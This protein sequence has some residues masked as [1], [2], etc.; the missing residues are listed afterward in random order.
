MKVIDLFSGV[1]GLSLGFENAG[2]ES[3]FAL[4]YNEGV[5]DGYRQNFKKT[6]VVCDDISSINLNETFRDYKNVDT[7]VIGGPPCQGFSQKGKRLGL[8]D[9]RNFLFKKYIEAVKII[10]PVGF[11]IENVPG[12]LSAEKGFFLDE[13]QNE[14]YKLNY[15]LSYRVLDASD[16]GI[17][18]KRK[19]AFI[20]GL[21]R[22]LEFNWPIKSEIIVTIEDAISDLP[23]LRS[24]EGETIQKYN[25]PPRS[26]YQA[27]LRKGSNKIY[28]HI[29][30]KHSSLVLERLQM[31]P[32]N[33]TRD[34]LPEEHLT[35]S[36][37]SGTWCR[38]IKNEPA[39]TI[40]TRF[41]TP[42]SG[43][44]T[45]PDQDRCLTVRE[46][47]RIQS[48]PDNFIFTGGK[49]NQM[50]Q[51]GNAVPPLLSATIAHR[52]VKSLNLK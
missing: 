48:F 5:I 21:K 4:D 49:S 47:A 8:N 20:I 3:I 38:L 17:P 50:L 19:R 51:V 32:E 26:E 29:A 39:R 16:Y 34:S 45:L 36:I 40:T 31:I 44:F 41:D 23:K 22:G 6:K 43:M 52:I 46:A 42:S 11:L 25:S 27:L 2:F 1:G 14:F 33:G 24:G 15:I 7:F 10:Q 9:D 12:L 30:T 35:K 13:I 18:Q 37:Y 28:N